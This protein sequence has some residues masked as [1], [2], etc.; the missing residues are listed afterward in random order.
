MTATVTSTEYNT[1]Y[2]ADDGIQ[3]CKSNRELNEGTDTNAIT[4]EPGPNVELNG[5]PIQ[6][7]DLIAP[8]R[9]IK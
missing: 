2:T 9:V 4:D 8:S 5:E 3:E 6:W 1:C 7:Q